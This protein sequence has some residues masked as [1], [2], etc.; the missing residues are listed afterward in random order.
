MIMLYYVSLDPK[1][2]RCN[3]VLPQIVEKIALLCCGKV[4]INI[5]TCKLLQKAW[6]DH[7]GTNFYCKNIDMI[8]IDTNISSS[9][10]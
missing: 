8:I 2:F 5:T 6:E 4:N 7:N 9:H 3:I 1:M 10:T